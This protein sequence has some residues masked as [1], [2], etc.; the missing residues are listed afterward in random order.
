[1]EIRGLFHLFNTDF[2]HLAGNILIGGRFPAW[3]LALCAGVLLAVIVAMTTRSDRRPCAHFV[4]ILYI[5]S[6]KH[7]RLLAFYI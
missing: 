1:V 4:S 3:A 5:L 7:S 6:Q 2:L